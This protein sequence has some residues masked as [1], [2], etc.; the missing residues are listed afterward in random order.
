M[1]KITLLF[2]SFFLTFSLSTSLYAANAPVETNKPVERTLSAKE[3]KKQQRLEKKAEKIGTFLEKRLEKK[4][5]KSSPDKKRALDPKLKSS[6][7]FL[8]ASILVSVI[9][10]VFAVLLGW[11]GIGAIIALLVYLIALALFV[12]A[13]IKFLGWLA[14]Q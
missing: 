1:K 7:I 11:T 10:S 2:L 3:L 12:V 5:A 8:A 14:D 13:V 6:L 4:L 9:G